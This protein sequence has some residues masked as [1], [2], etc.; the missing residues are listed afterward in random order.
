MVSQEWHLAKFADPVLLMLWSKWRVG[1]LVLQLRVNRH[2]RWLG[3]GLDWVG[4][5]GLGLT[6]C[7]P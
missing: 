6:H 5:K 7:R 3:K 1:A 4:G 2:L